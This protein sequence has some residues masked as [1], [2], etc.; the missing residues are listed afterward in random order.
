MSIIVNS[1]FSLTEKQIY[2]LDT[3]RNRLTL[4]YFDVQNYTFTSTDESIELPNGEII[5]TD[6]II[7]LDGLSVVICSIVSCMLKADKVLVV[8]MSVAVLEDIH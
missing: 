4:E 6:H 8:E 2:T 3:S 1:V 7:D 5:G